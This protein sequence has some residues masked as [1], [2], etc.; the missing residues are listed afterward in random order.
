MAISFPD[1]KPVPLRWRSEGIPEP[2]SDR[3]PPQNLEAEKGVLGSI[4][5]DDSVMPEVVELVDVPDFYRDDHQ[6]IFQAM[7]DLFEEGNPIDAVT[8]ADK[9]TIQGVFAKIGGDET[10]REIVDSVPHQANAKYY[11]GIV[12]DRAAARRLGEGATEL[13]NAVYRNQHTPQ[14]LLEIATRSIV[15][16]KIEDEEEEELSINVLPERMDK[17]AFRGLAGEIVGIVSPQTEACRGDPG[18]VHRG[19]RQRSRA[20]AALAPRREQPPLQ[21]VPLPG[22]AHGHRQEGDELGRVAVAGEPR[23]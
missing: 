14:E 20:Q 2:L 6:V 3:L 22:R 12:R 11:A 19:P 16:V 10:I 15:A 13:L 4:L 7:R 8:L 5:L 17:A 9:L 21:L 1:G 18:P 23:R